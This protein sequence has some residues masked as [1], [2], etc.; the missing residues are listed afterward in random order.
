[1]TVWVTPAELAD[2]LG[3]AATDPAVILAADTAN[4]AV[5]YVLDLDPVLDP[6]ATGAEPA[7][8]TAAITIGVDCYRRPLASGGLLAMDDLYARLPANLYR[9]IQALVDQHKTQWPVG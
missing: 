1:M 5:A 7:L 3:K 2:R 4:A 8:R 6:P 9:S